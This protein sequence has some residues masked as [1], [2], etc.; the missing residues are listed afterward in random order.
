MRFAWMKLAFYSNLIL[1]EVEKRTGVSRE[2]QR[3]YSSE[4]HIELVENLKKV[5]EKILK[6]REKGIVK[7][8]DD[9][10]IISLTPKESIEFIKKVHLSQN[11]EEML[12]GTTASPGKTKGR[13]VILSF[14]N[15][16][17]HND[18]IAKM[19]K[20][21]IIISEMTK[22]S[23][24]V[25]CEKAGA[26]VTDEGGIL[27]HAA[28]VSRELKIPCIIGTKNATQILKDGDLIEVDGDNGIIKIVKN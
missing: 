24:M 23:I 18:K 4:E 12:G 19:Q 8:L 16:E 9:G 7:I 20:G 13:V 10:N 27:S 25:A 15:T 6:E 3:Y 17:E 28:I 26:I 21:D 22:P 14:R 5:D 11:S 1:N 2:E